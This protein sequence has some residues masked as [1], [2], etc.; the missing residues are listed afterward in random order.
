MRIT[1]VNMGFSRVIV[2]YDAARGV[3]TIVVVVG[4]EL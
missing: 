1:H 4:D 2:E 3:C